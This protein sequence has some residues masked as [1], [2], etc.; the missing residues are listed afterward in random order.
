[1]SVKGKKD[2]KKDENHQLAIPDEK[3]DH[4]YGLSNMDKMIIKKFVVKGH[5]SGPM[6]SYR[7]HIKKYHKGPV[8]GPV[9]HSTTRMTN[10][11]SLVEERMNE[12]R[13]EQEKK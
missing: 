1:M 4:K 13:I 5:K 10:Y 3:K 7:K 11:L 6:Q 9:G 12:L 2:N 8:I